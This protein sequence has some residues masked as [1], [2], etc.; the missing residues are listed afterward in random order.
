LLDGTSPCHVSGSLLIFCAHSPAIVALV[1]ASCDDSFLDA[2]RSALGAALLAAG[3]GALFGLATVSHRLGLWDTQGLAPVVRYVPLAS[4]GGAAPCALPLAAALPAEAFLAPIDRWRDEIESA[5]EAIRPAHAEERSNVQTASGALQVSAPLP[6]CDAAGYVH[7][8]HCQAGDQNRAFGAS[9]DALLSLL[10]AP[11]GLV[12]ATPAAKAAPGGSA[13][14]F[15]SVRVLAFLS[16]PPDAGAGALDAGRW[17]EASPVLFPVGGTFASAAV[18][19]AAV[20]AA[21]A[22]A[23]PQTPF[24]SD[25]GARA[26]VRP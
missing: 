14:L 10:G 22:L 2:V 13:P 20:A 1:D 7:A 9:I 26:A 15:S 16:G 6:A 12:P 18:H 19:E 17:A 3:P 23:A 8:P 24:Y 5:L 4:G 21:D 11:G 25:A